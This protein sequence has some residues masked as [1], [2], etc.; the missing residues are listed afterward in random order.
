MGVPFYPRGQGHLDPEGTIW[1]STPGDPSYRI[2]AATIEGDT[3][4]IFE[5][6]RAPVPIPS[7]VRDS[8]IDVVRE[9]L[10]A[11]GGGNQN[12]SKVPEVRTAVQEVFTTADD[13]VWVQTASNSWARYDVYDRS[14]RYVR[15]VDTSYR[16]LS[17][18]R[19]IARGDYFWAVVVDELDVHY[20]VRAR[21]VRTAGSR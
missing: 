7:E 9:T 3:T 8:A 19:P 13:R 16:V 6:T 2:T 18:L 21:I 14:G 17:W 4:L 1:S 12:W 11:R 5:T 10:V 15:S 20:V